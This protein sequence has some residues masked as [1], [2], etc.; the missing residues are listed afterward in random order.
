MVIPYALMSDVDMERSRDGLGLLKV[1]GCA[2][3]AKKNGTFC[4][5]KEGSSLKLDS[6]V[7]K[8]VRV[9]VLVCAPPLS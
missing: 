7:P 2:K 1:I 9:V 4:S 8:V 5:K 3:I 6:I